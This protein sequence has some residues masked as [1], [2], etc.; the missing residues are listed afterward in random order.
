MML[1]RSG[2]GLTFVAQITESAK[3]VISNRLVKSSGQLF[4]ELLYS[5]LWMKG[6][7]LDTLKARSLPI[8]PRSNQYADV[9]P[10]IFTPILPFPISIYQNSI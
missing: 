2:L 8:F 6:R 5:P 9:S 4:A 3:F 7:F 10:A 1:V